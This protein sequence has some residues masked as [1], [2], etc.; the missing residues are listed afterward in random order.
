MRHGT[1]FR[2][3]LSTLRAGAAPHSA[4]AELEVVSRC[5]PL[6]FHANTPMKY[7]ATVFL[8][9]AI[10]ASALHAEST[11]EREFKQLRE[12]RDKAMAAAADPIN[13]RYQAAL[14]Q[15]LRRATQGNDLETALKLK[16]EIGTPTPAGTP[17]A[18]PTTGRKPTKRQ[19]EKLLVDGSWLLME[20]ADSPT[21]APT[22]GAKT[23]FTD[24][25]KFRSANGGVHQWKIEQDGTVKLLTEAFDR[26]GLELTFQSNTETTLK[27]VGAMWPGNTVSRFIAVPK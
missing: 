13:R 7:H 19:I 4:V 22:P 15:L 2:R 25:G 26:Y 1:C 24:D 8:L 21:A 3:R 9:L 12:Q 17:S 6:S 14:E 16:Q 23:V 10:T 27:R 11:F 18:P 5:S 20:H